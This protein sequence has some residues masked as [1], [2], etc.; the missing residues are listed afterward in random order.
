MFK[1][2]YGLLLGKLGMELLMPSWSKRN[3]LSPV[4][5]FS[6]YAIKDVSRWWVDDISVRYR[7]GIDFGRGRF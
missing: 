7:W 2:I 6:L 1:F 3:E 4:L 5:N